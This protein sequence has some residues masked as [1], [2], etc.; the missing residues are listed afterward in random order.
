M[1][2]SCPA[3]CSSTP[4]RSAHP[5][6][7]S[8]T[9]TRRGTSAARPSSGQAR[10]S[11]R[12]P[13]TACA[14]TAGPPSD[15][16]SH[17][18]ATRASRTP[19]ACSR[20]IAS[21]KRREPTGSGSPCSYGLSPSRPRPRRT[22][23]RPA[24]VRVSFARRRRR[25]ALRRASQTMACHE[26]NWPT[27]APLR[28]EPEQTPGTSRPPGQRSP[29]WAGRAVRIPDPGRPKR[30]VSHAPAALRSPPARAGDGSQRMLPPAGDS[31]RRTSRRSSLRELCAGA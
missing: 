4:S 25:V 22:A 28:H 21:G 13:S 23:G 3:A 8:R 5:A 7:C 9:S 26:R 29:A 16:S 2:P 20:T 18:C 24:H 31:G 12:A 11:G 19:T 1:T 30:P 15:G 27:L 14:W 10:R 17:G 6:P